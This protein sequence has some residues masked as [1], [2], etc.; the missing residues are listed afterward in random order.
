MSSP[1]HHWGRTEAPNR[2][3]PFSVMKGNV[4]WGELTPRQ[5]QGAAVVLS[6]REDQLHLLG[7]T[8]IADL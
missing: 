3:A 6:F 2:C 7:P 8:V 5:N 4:D 1:R